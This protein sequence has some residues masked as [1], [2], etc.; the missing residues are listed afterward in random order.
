MVSHSYK[1]KHICGQKRSPNRIEQQHLTISYVLYMLCIYWLYC[2]ILRKAWWTLDYLTWLNKLPCIS[3]FLQTENIHQN[4]FHTL[5]YFQYDTIQDGGWKTWA[6]IDYI[7]CGFFHLSTNVHWIV[8]L[9][10]AQIL[11]KIL[12]TLEKKE[13]M[14]ERKYV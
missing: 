13:E 14:K 1:L 8:K 9:N 11:Q 2:P 5:E 4:S 10:N 12:C 7:R 6:G 3:T